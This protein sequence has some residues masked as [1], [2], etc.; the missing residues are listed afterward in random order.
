MQTITLADTRMITRRRFWIVVGLFFLSGLSALVYEILWVRLL[1]LVFGNT[2]QA[3]TT[4]LAAFM[5]GLALGSFF[6][7]R[8]LDKRSLDPL[9]VYA[10]LEL[11]IAVC[12]ILFPLYLNALTPVYRWLYHATDG[13]GFWLVLARFAACSVFLVIPSAM[14]GGTLPA[15]AKAMVERTEEVGQRLG[16]LY[17]VNTFGGVLGTVLCGFLLIPSL[18]TQWTNFLSAGLNGLVALAAWR[19]A[20]TSGASG[21]TRTTTEP[22]VTKSDPLPP[23][24]P[25]LN[26]R[27]ILAAYFVSGLAALAL[28]VIWTRVLLL[29]F[30]STTYAF[31][32]ML[33]I[34]LTGIAIGSALMQRWVDRARNLEGLLGGL[35][36]VGALVVLGMTFLVDWL[37]FCYLQIIGKIGMT[38]KGDIVGRIT[39]SVL[40]M[41]LPTL[42]FGGIFPVIARLVVRELSHVGRGV[43]E[44]YAANTV[45]AIAGSLLGGFALLPLFGMQRS[46]EIVAGIMILTGLAV[47]GCAM[48]KTGKKRLCWV[49]G[50]VAAFVALISTSKPWD[51]KILATGAY[52][53][54]HYYLSGKGMVTLRDRLADDRL[55]FY[56]EGKTSTIAVQLVNGYRKGLRVDGKPEISTAPVDRRIGRLLGHLPMLLHHNPQTVFNL[57]LGGGFTSAG[58]AAHPVR[59]I[60]I[61]EI[62]PCVAEAARH[63]AGENRNLLDDPR[64]HLIFND[65][66]NHL[67]LTDQKYDVI[68]SDPLEPVVSGAASLF[69]VDHFRIARARLAPGGLMCQWI[70]L[71]EMQLP[72]YQSIMRSFTAV[73]PHV[74][75]WF[76]GTDSILIGSEKPLTIDVGAMAARMNDPRVQNDLRDIGLDDPHRLLGCFVSLIENGGEFPP[77]I[78]LNTDNFPYIEFSTPKKRWAPTEAQNLLFFTQRRQFPIHARFPDTSSERRG[79]DFFKVQTLVLDALYLLQNGK[80]KDA[81]TLAR[82]AITLDSDNPFAIEILIRS[83]DILAQRA[84]QNGQT[85]EELG[86]Y[87]E[88]L[89]LD[90]TAM[91]GLL[92][93]AKRNF[94]L[95][96]MDQAETYATRALASYPEAPEAK[97]VLAQIYKARNNI[98]ESE[99]LLRALVA[100][101]PDYAP[102]RAALEEIRAVPR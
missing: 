61:A 43:G 32:V 67:L 37:P 90:P 68:T 13:S 88:I 74:S 89:A 22:A 36:C 42:V 87:Q 83:N 72:E 18:G 40:F 45:G 34:F 65:G 79:R 47:L 9:L 66:R 81:T 8:W 91:E 30:G 56:R 48:K 82:Q 60:D 10:G 26:P 31:T 52:Y 94:E 71:Y 73:F 3:T 50:S 6:V 39:V 29:V 100:D 28:E 49:V 59:Q 80:R 25:V 27:L 1:G 11:G 62:E 15:L 44:A 76:T 86:H 99:R 63:F 2:V 46:I 24:T 14:M 58:L 5:A 12:A 23:V 96:K 4:V 57:G 98:E 16:V 95:G 53:K 21:S 77:T 75:V 78:P 38:W 54:P 92:P 101:Y 35:L 7:G 41:L 17:A 20:K 55:L 93:L 97:L 70:P 33:A 85:E 19:L 51:K 69:T 64:V 102:A 84:R